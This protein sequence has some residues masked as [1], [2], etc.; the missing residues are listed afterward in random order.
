MELEAKIA[1]LSF[2]AKTYFLY[3]F[4]VRKIFRKYIFLK[5]ELFHM[6][7]EAEN[8]R[9]FQDFSEK[10]HWNAKRLLEGCDQLFGARKPQKWTVLDAQ[11][12]LHTQFFVEL[13]LAAELQPVEVPSR[14]PNIGRNR[15]SVQQSA[16][17]MLCDDRKCSNPMLAA[18]KM[19]VILE[20][21]S[22]SHNIMLCYQLIS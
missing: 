21:K 19:N 6:W 2:S 18:S 4:S 10:C 1:D 3:T 15:K 17:K 7:I 22:S 16:P 8:F 13:P 12:L 11:I 5:F 9:K 20:S 14:R